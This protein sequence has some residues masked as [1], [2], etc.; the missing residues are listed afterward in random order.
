MGWTGAIMLLLTASRQAGGPR[1]VWKVDLEKTGLRSF[2]TQVNLTWSR[3]QNVI[4]LSPD[5]LLVYQVNQ[6]AEPARLTGRNRSGGAGN[7]F[8]EVRILDARNG[9]IIQKLRLPASAGFSTILPTRNGKLIVRTG[10]SL[11][12]CTQTF[13]ILASR[14]LSLTGEAPVEL[15]QIGISP[16]GGQIALVHERATPSPAVVT[17]EKAISEV[18]ILDT[19]TLKTV[20][21]FSVS[22]RLTPWSVGDGFLV[23]AAPGQVTGAPRFGLLDFDGNW[24]ALAVK[25]DHCNDHLIALGA[26]TLAAW[27]CGRLAV[28]NT[29]G[30]KLFTHELGSRV[31]VG[32]ARRSGRYLAV[33]LDRHVQITL[34]G[35]NFP[36]TMPKPQRLD[37][38]DLS[39]KKR[40]L[41][42]AVKSDNLYYAIS[43][44][45][46]LA[47]IEGSTVALYRAEN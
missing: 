35:T 20:R 27:G 17:D 18:E 13:Q 47:V 43:D 19:G 40:L 15:W 4:F 28:V 2:Q 14:K 5:R 29:D 10:E 38:Y 1:P 31:T 41:S 9:H 36:F 30:E 37:L 34:P 32:S 22:R 26:G 3:Q 25:G 11:R 33:E 7:F 24:S 39:A 6:L 16:A 46:G 8:L 45:G 21:Q 12:L 23:T 44:N 42:L